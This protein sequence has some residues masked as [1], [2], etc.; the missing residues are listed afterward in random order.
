LLLCHRVADRVY[1]GEAVGPEVG[2]HVFVRL[3]LATAIPRN[4][5]GPLGIVSAC[6]GRQSDI[7]NGI[8]IEVFCWCNVREVWLVEADLRC[9]VESEEVPNRCQQSLTGVVQ[10]GHSSQQPLR[11][12]TWSTI[13]TG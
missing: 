13:P 3:H 7:I 9:V 1:T 5:W 4:V 2:R 11:T 6:I 12:A 10:E 8:Q